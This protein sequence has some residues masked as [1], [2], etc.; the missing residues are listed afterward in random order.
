MLIDKFISHIRKTDPSFE[1]RIILDI[2]S[3]DLDQ[4][5]EFSSVYQN[6][7]IYAFEPNPE[8]FNICLNKSVNYENI[9]VE[10]LAISDKNGSLDFYITHGNVGAS[11]L[12]EPINV[13]FA[14]T[15][16]FT[17]ISVESKRLDDWLEQNKIDVV[18][19]MWLDTQG[20]ELSALKS[21]GDKLKKVKFIH[22]EASELP[23]YKG[24]LLKTDLVEFLESV[25]FELIFINE[26]YHPFN[27]GDIIATNKS[28]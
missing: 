28:V 20:V 25:G 1:P 12:L 2:G 21:M 6:S 22:C 24:H 16:N 9:N 4:S 27:E 7:K 8:Q 11:S 15:Q 13:P 23:Y 5:I 14:S 17:K 10:Q 18:D 3:R 26:A 19:I